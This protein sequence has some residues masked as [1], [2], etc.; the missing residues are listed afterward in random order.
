MESTLIKLGKKVKLF[1]KS[2]LLPA[3]KPV[4]SYVRRFERIKTPEK[5]CAMTFDDGPMDLP[6]A[7]D[8]FGGE[9]LTD[10]L[11]DTLAE[12][13]AKGVFDVVGDTSENY[14]DVCGPAGSPTWGGTAFDH[15]PEFGQ[16]SKGGAQNCPRLIDR[17]LNEGHQITN[18][19]YRHIIF[20]KKPYVYGKRQFQGKLDDVTSDMEKLHGLLADRHGYQMEMTRPPHYVDQIDGVFTAYDAC[21]LLNYQ[22]LAASFDGQ[23]WLPAKTGDQ[24]LAEVREMT[25]PVRRA[26]AQDQAFFCGQIIFQKDGYNMALRTPVAFGLREQLELLTKAGYR[27]MTVSELI[28]LSPFADTGSEDPDFDQFRELQRTHAV[29]YSDNTL[30]PDTPMTKGELAMLL[31]PRSAAVEGRIEKLRAGDKSFLHR[32]SGALNWCAEQKLF[33]PGTAPEAPLERA[34]LLKAADFFRGDIE[35]SLTR[36][37]VLRSFRL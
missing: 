1:A 32:Y 10:V 34:D 36:R 33:S 16:D 7:P 29:V 27:I 28:E 3:P 11:L 5:V 12:F 24:Q 19:G 18:H 35:G 14:P 23:G 37:A 4:V 17:I 26:L 20:G 30:R 2:V 6:C 8:R 9:A 21:A 25:E 15:Y 31:A 22:Y 13:G